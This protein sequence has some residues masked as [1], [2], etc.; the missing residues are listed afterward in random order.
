MQASSFLKHLA[1][2]HATGAALARCLAEGSKAISSMFLAGGWEGGDE[3]MGPPVVSPFAASTGPTGDPPASMSQACSLEIACH[4]IT[5][6]SSCSCPV[7][8][9]T[10]CLPACCWAESRVEA[11]VTA[12][13]SC[14]DS[15]RAV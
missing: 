9:I 7:L 4:D 15:Y 6:I 1:I 3:L 14:V 13:S 12:G 5:C 8:V 10:T 2:G 11:A